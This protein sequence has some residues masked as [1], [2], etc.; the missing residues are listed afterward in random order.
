M[1]FRY[2][3][4]ELTA[5]Q[6]ANRW[7][8][9]WSSVISDHVSRDFSVVEI[10]AGI[11]S[12]CRV[13]EKHFAYYVGLEPDANLVDI[14]KK[15]FPEKKF[16]VGTV[17]TFQEFEA[18][19]LVLYIDVLEHI[20]NDAVELEKSSKR[21]SHGSF[22]GIL[23]PAHMQ[24]Y[25]KFDKRIGHFRRYS[26]ESLRMVLPKGFSVI[27]CEELDSVG[28]LLAKI[29][30]KIGGIEKISPLQVRIWDLMVPISRL[31]DKLEFTRGKSILLIA[32]KD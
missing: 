20:E 7:K 8:N 19:S 13:I 21:M 32:H 3:G 2:I 18:R 26:I 29:S 16:V 15:A 30:K 9:Y 27:Y 5:F 14:A 24:L 22:L 17:D 12:N 28:F 11:G 31:L 1:N 23:V 6:H 4:E 10:G 25:S